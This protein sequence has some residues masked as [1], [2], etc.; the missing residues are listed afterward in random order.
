MIGRERELEKSIC[1]SPRGRWREEKI[2][3]MVGRL[4][5]QGIGRVV[6]IGSGHTII[7]YERENEIERREREKRENDTKRREK[8]ETGER[9]RE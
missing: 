6:Y 8:E 7:L 3:E 1:H 4:R 2:R 5:E 9:E